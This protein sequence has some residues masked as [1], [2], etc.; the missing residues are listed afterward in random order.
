[1][2][3]KKLSPDQLA[4]LDI[5][6]E[7]YIKEVEAGNI[8][9]FPKQVFD[10]LRPFHFGGMPL[11]IQL[12]IPEM[13]NGLCYDKST[14]L[15][16]AFAECT[17]VHADIESLRIKTEG[18][19]SPIAAQHAYIEA[20]GY[21]FD[22]SVGL[23]FK[24]DA[25]DR[26]EKPTI[27]KTHTK[28][29]CLE[30]LKQDG[31]LAGDFEQDKH[32][33]VMV[34]PIVEHVVNNP[35]HVATEHNQRFLLEEI[36]KLKTGINFGEM[37]AEHEADMAIMYS[38]PEILDAKFG[39]VRDAHG[40]E[41]SRNGVPNPYYTDPTTFEE[42]MKDPVKL[43]KFHADSHAQILKENQATITNAEAFLEKVERNPGINI[44]EMA[45][46]D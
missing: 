44:Y 16:L 17:Q 10:A 23:I 1:M 27:N 11:S 13:C 30:Y 9:P 46:K 21:V 8:G 26:I 24:K 6:N 34:L 4:R 32:S 19:P 12:F 41:V 15:S 29:E 28:Q 42:D 35:K 18:D 43:A 33:L 25:Y 20:Y 45:D 14:L 5:I 2:K 31:T 39:I 40:R 38:Q 7:Q 22:T 3:D 36:A 37:V